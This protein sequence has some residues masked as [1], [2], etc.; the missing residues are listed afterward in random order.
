MLKSFLCL[1][2]A[3]PICLSAKDMTPE[4]Y[5]E[6]YKDEAIKEMK[7]AG[8]PASITLAQGMLE[9]G[10]GNS[11]LAR[12]ANNHFGIKC[13]S[14][15]KGPTIIKDD[16]QKNECFRKYRTVLDSYHDHSEFLRGK[17]RYAFL[18]EL[19]IDDYEGWAKGL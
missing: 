3:L 11:M 9:S 5:I 15:W 7:R 14:D 4:E 18:F 13:H 12:K 19:D 16:D 6:E 10:N 17:S 1:L 2:I 8:I